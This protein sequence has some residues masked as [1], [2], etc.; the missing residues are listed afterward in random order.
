MLIMVSGA[1]A[2]VRTMSPL[3]VG[4]LITPQNGNDVKT[5]AESG[6]TWAAD[7]GCF[8][9]LDAVKYT[10]MLDRLAQHRNDRLK[11]VTVPDVVADH[12]AT[13][14]LF[15]EWIGAVDGR[16]LPAAFVAQDGATIAG[17][18][19]GKIAAVFIGGSTRWKLGEQAQSIIRS[20]QQRGKWVH[21]GRVNTPERLRVCKALGVD[22]VDGSQFSR[23]SATH[24]PGAVRIL[25][26][27]QLY[28]WS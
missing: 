13:V 6:M 23:W 24:L 1:T 14:A 8:T 20:A 21:V 3:F 19:W 11:F 4:R 22:S 17:T 28:M 9:G 25:Q 10:K 15:V 18:P 26:E 2:T 12:A 27:Q 7:N 5:L 16:G